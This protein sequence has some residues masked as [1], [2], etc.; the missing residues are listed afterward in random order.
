[1]RRQYLRKLCADLLK[2]RW[3]DSD[4]LIREQY[5]TLEDISASGVCIQLEESLEPGT[6]VTIVHPCASYQ[7]V[8]RHCESRED[9]FFV[10]VEFAE[11]THWSPAEFTPAHLLE[12]WLQ[13]VH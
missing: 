8:V 10:G 1:M 2:A 5:V 9:L 12:F 4:G 13:K 7:G 3:T 11:G 6:A